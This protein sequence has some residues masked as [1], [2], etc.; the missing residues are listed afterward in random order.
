[1]ETTNNYFK[2]AVIFAAG[3]GRRMG[4]C[5]KGMV[6]FCGK[7]LIS[8]SI[9]ALL[10]FGI[11]DIYILYREDDKEIYRIYDYYPK[12]VNIQLIKDTY[13]KGPVQ[14]HLS[15]TDN[16]KYP[17]ITM[18]CDLI[19]SKEEFHRMLHQGIDRLEKNDAIVAIIENPVEDEEKSFYIASDDTVHF[20]NAHSKEKLRCAGYIYGWKKP[21]RNDLVFYNSLNTNS[22]RNFFD[23]Y[24][25]N[26]NVGFMTIKHMW[27]VDT[28]EKLKKSE[29][30]FMNSTIFQEKG[31][32]DNK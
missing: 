4:G 28:P 24:T 18:D 26:K 3:K 32:N 6:S 15:L 7:P 5:S 19:F 13:L 12:Q 29:E 14:A 9:D 10:A 23:Y 20:V 2:S 30:V 25:T 8:I 31:Y 27:D 21:I 17:L 1:M 16:I 11:T 22:Y